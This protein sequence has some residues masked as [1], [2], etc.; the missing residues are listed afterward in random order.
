MKLKVD[1]NVPF[2]IVSLLRNLGHDVHSVFDEGLNGKSDKELILACQK[3][4]RILMTLD[5]DFASIQNYPPHENKG[6][7]VLRPPSQDLKTIEGVVRA[8]VGQYA[9]ENFSG[10]LWIV[11]MHQIRVRASS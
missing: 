2:S 9:E 5:L 6:I 4:E 7:V 3:E 8:F 11:E 1:E 10:K